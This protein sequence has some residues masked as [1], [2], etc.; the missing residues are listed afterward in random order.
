MTIRILGLGNVLMGDDG[1]G[2]CVLHHLVSHWELPEGVEVQ[3]LG[4]PGLDLI[5]FLSGAGTIILVDTVK[6]DGQPGETRRYEKADILRHAPTPRVS[7]HDPGV[8]EAL[9]ALEFDGQ[10]PSGVILLGAIP[11]RV[12]MTT[13]LTRPL[14]A[15]VPVVAQAVVDE[16]GRLGLVARRRAEPLSEDPWWSRGSSAP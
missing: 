4:T 8:K 6:A 1:F 16:L 11:G 10:A 12:D 7:P 5:P 13:E 9:L 14:G 2:P 3:D 15:A